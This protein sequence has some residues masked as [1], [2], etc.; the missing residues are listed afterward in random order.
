M[1]TSRLGSS[2]SVLG[3]EGAGGLPSKGRDTGTHHIRCT[4]V[5]H[6]EYAERG[7]EYRILFLFSLFCECMH[8]EDIR[9]HGKYRAQQAGNG[10]HILVVAPQEY[11]R[12]T[13]QPEC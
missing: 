7:H 13:L 3:V 1:H 10:I 12:L 5:L 11:V 8:L 2:S 9:I 6:V 4:V